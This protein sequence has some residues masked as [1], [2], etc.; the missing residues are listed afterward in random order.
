MQAVHR[1]LQG[2]ETRSIAP[3]RIGDFPGQTLVRVRPRAASICQTDVN[4]ARMGALPFTLGHEFAGLLDDGTPVGVEP[5]DPCGG[6]AECLRADYHFCEKGHAMV[7]GIGRNGGMAEEVLVPARSIVPLPTGL[8]VRDAC[9]IEPLSVHLHAFALARLEGRQRVCVVGA[10]LTGFGLLG[11]AAAKARGCEVDLDERA[12]HAL[13]AAEQL[14]L[15][16]HPC[17]RYDVVVEA[18]GS[19]ES[20]A[21]AAELARPGGT[22]LMV[23]GYYSEF[24]RVKVLPFVAKELTV[25]WG[26]Y[27]GHHAAG[28]D[29]DSAAS[30]LARRPEIARAVIS[31]RFPLAAAREAFALVESEAPSLKVVLEP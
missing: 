4:L 11:G 8:D 21:R 6:C 5:L 29:A 7:L 1:T 22:V 23:A 12:P 13:A 17:D 18:D 9:L 10:N 14:G 25:I 30:L 28:R 26:T 19:E 3:D 15:G 31:H 16:I 2:I 20:I 24:K 27:Y